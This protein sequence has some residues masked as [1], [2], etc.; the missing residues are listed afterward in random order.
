VA[1]EGSRSTLSEPPESP[2]IH[3]YPRKFPNLPGPYEEEHAPGDEGDSDSD[4]DAEAIK[5]FG[6]PFSKITSTAK[7]KESLKGLETL[8]TV[9][10]L[11]RIENVQQV[12]VALQDEWIGLEA[13]TAKATPGDGIPV[14]RNPRKPREYFS[15]QDRVE[16]D[17]YGFEQDTHHTKLGMQRP[18]E[19]REGRLGNGSRSRRMRQRT[20]RVIDVDTSGSPESMQNVDDDASGSRTRRATRSRL[21]SSRIGSESREQSPVGFSTFPSGKR[22]GRPPMKAVK[23]TSR[24]QELRTEKAR[25]SA[26][27]AS[28]GLS[29]YAETPDGSEEEESEHED[30]PVFK[31]PKRGR[32][33]KK[34]ILAR[35]AAHRLQNID[36][37]IDSA[38]NRALN[39]GFAL[40]DDSRPTSSS[41]DNSS[42]S[43][44]EDA[45]NL[46]DAPAALAVTQDEEDGY[47]SAE[48]KIKKQR[49]RKPKATAAADEETEDGGTD[50]D[51]QTGDGDQASKKGIKSAKSK[52]LK[53]SHLSRVQKDKWANDDGSRKEKQASAMRVR[54]A[55]HA[56]MKNHGYADGNTLQGLKA[57]EPMPTPEMQAEVEALI[58]K[59]LADK[60][61]KLAKS[62]KAAAKSEPEIVDSS[63]PVAAQPPQIATQEP[64]EDSSATPALLTHPA[65][66]GTP[67]KVKAE[68]SSTD[69]G[70]IEK[71]KR[72]QKMVRLPDGREVT[73][74]SKVMLDR[75]QK[76]KAAEAAG[77]PVPQIGRYAAGSNPNSAS[78]T[79]RAQSETPV[80]AGSRRPSQPEN[81]HGDAAQAP[82]AS[83]NATTDQAKKRGG[84]RKRKEDPNDQASAADVIDSVEPLEQPV[85]KRSRKPSATHE[86]K[87]F[88]GPE[89]GVNEAPMQPQVQS[90]SAARRG[91]PKKVKDEHVVVNST[92]TV[93]APLATTT[94][95]PYTNAQNAQPSSGATISDNDPSSTS[96][97]SKRAH[98]P[99]IP[100][101]EP[102]PILPPSTNLAASSQASNT[103]RKRAQEEETG[104]EEE[105]QS[106]PPLVNPLVNQPK[107]KGRPR[108]HPLPELVTG[109]TTTPI[110]ESSK[111]RKTKASSVPGPKRTDGSALNAGFA[112]AMSTGRPKRETR[113]PAS[114]YDGAGSDSDNENDNDEPVQRKMSEYEQFQALT[115]P[116]LNSP[117]GLRGKRPAALR[118]STSFIMPDTSSEIEEEDEYQDIGTAEQSI[119]DADVDLDADE[120]A[121]GEIEIGEPEEQ[122]QNEL[123]RQFKSEYDQFQAISSPNAG[124]VLGKRKRKSV[125]G[126]EGSGSGSP[127]SR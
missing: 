106:A 97:R 95:T 96:S 17:V 34:D 114:F 124:I 103:S 82:I 112:A 23:T 85:K 51:P 37:T 61:A 58:E 110:D 41:S 90:P 89:Q 125:L 39:A 67:R 108:K 127:F 4:R 40:A 113:R 33:S 94:S 53:S 15:N 81:Y 64:S 91:R 48:I 12:L 72:P 68:S 3:A 122:M 118:A 71:Q 126:R 107:K 100:F 45:A 120:D 84:K 74:Q 36:N 105:A 111:R 60:A 78:A 31:T 104:A 55:R 29:M 92:E 83:S 87:S 79:P 5:L 59:R 80:H 65:A 88:Y 54:W 44:Q 123:A 98:K 76:R 52:L 101:G 50:I 73:A 1:S 38:E 49:G 9:H 47:A 70:A 16:A 8:P 86:P 25:K 13:S 56:V 22:I 19:Q 42:E 10:A 46:D 57:D 11:D 63:V 18:I 116:A 119:G 121:D 30:A 26:P 93:P 109:P 62:A 20:D 69:R 77:L 32:P 66:R 21:P 7:F 28:S 102:A 99:K 14:V 24:V 115:S 27:R 35:E 43:L 117:L 6:K 2:A 75:W